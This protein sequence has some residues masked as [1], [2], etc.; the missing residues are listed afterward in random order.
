MVKRALNK[1]TQKREREREGER[2]MESSRER[3]KKWKRRKCKS[4]NPLVPNKNIQASI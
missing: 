2:G 3:R 4:A 1:R